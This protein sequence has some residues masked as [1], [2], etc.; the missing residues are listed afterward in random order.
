MLEWSNIKRATRLLAYLRQASVREDYLFKHRGCGRKSTLI[1]GLS[2]I[3][4]GGVENP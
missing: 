4:L 2:L 1:P 3:P